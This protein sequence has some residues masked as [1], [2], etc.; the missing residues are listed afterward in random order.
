MSR[1]KTFAEVPSGWASC[2]LA[3]FCE[4]IQGQSPPGDTYN[5]D[6]K[7]L[8][9][10]QGKA[11]FGEDYP[12]PRKWCIAPL[13]IAEEGDVLISI[14]APVGPTNLCMEPSC[15][16]RGL[17]AIRPLSDVASRF[18]LY[19]LR[20]SESEL[21][22]QATGSTFPAIG[23][24]T[25]RK[26]RFLLPPLAEQRRIVA[27]IETQ[28]TRL[29]AAV[30]ALERARANLKRYRAAILAAA[31]EGR[32]VPT[33]AELAR[34]EGRSYEHA[35]VLAARTGARIQRIEAEER[36]ASVRS[37]R[38][39]ADQLDTPEQ[40]LPSIP[41]GWVW[42]QIGDLF[43]VFVGATPS[44]GNSSYWGGN[45]PWVSSGEVAF[46]TIRDTRERITEIG[47][48]SSSTR[49]HRPG[50]VL[51]GMIGEGR[52]RGQAAIIA[53]EACN[54]QNS[55]AIRVSETELS[56]QYVY[57]FLEATYEQTRLS[58][59]GNNQPALNKQRV[60]EIWIPIP[61]LAEQ[62]RIVA[63]VER[64]LSGVERLE[65]AM[66][67]GLARA[68]RLRQAVLREAFAGRLVPQ[69]PTDEPASV[70]LARIRAER[71]AAG[72]AKR[73]RRAAL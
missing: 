70:L 30:A 49:L 50:T 31:C 51:L 15:I 14:R 26:H 8:P 41:E 52:T 53:I 28:L 21:A 7:G 47:L 2:E 12:V 44:R 17:A 1:E 9:F 66:S 5:T 58:S 6:G 62:E 46:C 18:V 34:Q 48:R 11:E 39:D 35:S 71:V 19:G 42:R 20:A 36:P 22:A 10:Y 55:A 54:N 65:A 69:D 45:V 64:R 16:G 13:R 38:A 67:A 40:I 27:A 61:P 4:L 72:P 73:G 56:P 25:L 33:E 32:L 60:R 23:G 43:R 57:R 29:D 63:E 24:Q 37:C 68:E 59:S 3:D